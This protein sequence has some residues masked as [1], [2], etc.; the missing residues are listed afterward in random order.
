MTTD[1]SVTLSVVEG[2]H[3]RPPHAL[4][5]MSRQA[6]HEICLISVICVPLN[7]KINYHLD[8][9]SLTWWDKNKSLSLNKIGCTSEIFCISPGLHYLCSVK[10]R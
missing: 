5:E 8:I 7:T 10:Q 3:V 6:R 4:R 9:R 1:V 2:S